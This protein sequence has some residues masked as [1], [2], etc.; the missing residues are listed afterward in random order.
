YDR[1][2]KGVEGVLPAHRQRQRNGCGGSP[3][4]CGDG[5]DC[6]GA[7]CSA[8]P[9]PSTWSW[10]RRPYGACARPPCRGWGG[11]PRR[12]S[13]KGSTPRW[14]EIMDRLDQ[15]LVRVAEAYLSEQA[16]DLIHLGV[17]GK[18][19]YR[20]DFLDQPPEVIGNGLVPPGQVKRRMK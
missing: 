19:R 18:H 5:G 12:F 7:G 15:R 8:R 16:E 13:W 20:A 1:H 14:E 11:S 3:R 10:R 9:S 17:W 2:L 6:L 4:R